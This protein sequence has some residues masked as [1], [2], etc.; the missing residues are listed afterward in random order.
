M[1]L[2]AELCTIVWL[3]APNAGPSV[4]MRCKFIGIVIRWTSVGLYY[5]YLICYSLE[6]FLLSI[7][8]LNS[9]DSD[10]LLL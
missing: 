9:P 3:S 4:D 1:Q 10:C 6:A 7:P 5:V 8:I 2:G